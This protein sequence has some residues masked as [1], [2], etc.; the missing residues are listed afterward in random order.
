MKLFAYILIP[1]VLITTHF[2]QDTYVPSPVQKTF[3][4]RYPRIGE[5]SWKRVGKDLYV[6]RFSHEG[7]A[8]S[9]FIKSEGTWQYTYITFD[10]DDL[11]KCITNNVLQSQSFSQ[12]QIVK[13]EQFYSDKRIKDWHI[14]VEDSTTTTDSIQADQQTN[15]SKM[16]LLEYDSECDFMTRKTL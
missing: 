10:V 12:P 4:S 14:T 3:N 11:P 8:K 2:F 16:Y 1:V 9:C 5:P 7:Q 15:T 13:A 6:A